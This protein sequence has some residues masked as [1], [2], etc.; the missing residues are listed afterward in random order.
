MNRVIPSE[1]EGPLNWWL[2]RQAWD[3][4]FDQLGSPSPSSRVGMTGRYLDVS[5]RRYVLPILAG[6]FLLYPVERCFA[7]FERAFELTRFDCF[8]YFA[9]LRARFHSHRD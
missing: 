8:E 4:F 5:R 6:V 1:C 2:P 9:E 7:C 3:N